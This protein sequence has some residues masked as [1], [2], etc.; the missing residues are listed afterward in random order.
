MKKAVLTKNIKPVQSVQ[1][2]ARKAQPS[3][4][5]RFY[6]V[7]Q[8]QIE[9]RQP[10][11]AVI[12][13][14]MPAARAV[15]WATDWSM[16]WIQMALLA[17]LAFIVWNGKN[18]MLPPMHF[19]M[20][21]LIN[22]ANDPDPNQPMP[23][24]NAAD[25]QYLA[26]QQ[27]IQPIQQ[28]GV[29]DKAAPAVQLPAWTPP[30]TQASTEIEKSY[31]AATDSGFLR[32]VLY[33]CKVKQAPCEMLLAI[34]KLESDMGRH[35]TNEYSSARGSMQIIRTEFLRMVDTYGERN[36]NNLI[37]YLA[38]L[39]PD[40][41]EAQG[42]AHDIGTLQYA[43]AYMKRPSYRHNHV[44]PQKIESELLRLN[45]R[46]VV[47][48]LFVA[49]RLADDNQYL[50]QHT[51]L[52]P[53]DC[54]RFAYLAYVHGATAADLTLAAYMDPAVR[55]HPVAPLLTQLYTHLYAGSPGAQSWAKDTTHEIL[56][57]N[58]QNLHTTVGE[59]VDTRVAPF[60]QLSQGYRVILD[61]EAARGAIS[62]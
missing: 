9:Q 18:L 62:L 17:L 54:A 25:A 15:P 1:S 14:R 44:L 5:A 32:S 51:G 16:P 47:Q 45:D 12:S 41:R 58:G 33:A 10:R 6:D 42:L 31:Q 61:R 2:L 22:A 60:L 38:F 28:T 7:L 52:S 57:N 21:N 11:D 37:G 53:T 4:P 29:P 36:I 40:S 13:M 48:L 55:K 49:D 35:T 8:D 19:P 3:R 30:I 46:P 27:Q 20:G 39:P 23:A 50:S 26:Q 34:A 56:V 43:I 24:D 59:F